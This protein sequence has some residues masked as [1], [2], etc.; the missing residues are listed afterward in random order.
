MSK[1]SSNASELSPKY[2]VMGFLYI[3]PMYGYELHKHLKTSLREVWHI[4]QSQAY[5]IIN[6]L[7]KDNWITAKTQPQEK[8]P[9][10][11]L[12]ALTQNGT[13]AFETWL[14]APTPGSARAIRVEFITRLFFAS[15]LGESQYFRLIQEQSDSIRISLEDLYSRLSI[16][17]SDLVFNRMGIDLRISQLK[18]ILDWVENSTK[19][20]KEGLNLL[21]N[22]DH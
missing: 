14:F 1:S 22:E 16:I 7:E 10:R 3:R 4:S 18:A 6:N 11:E 15:H 9:D 20:F 8:L 5:N 19:Y 21:T 17:P 13:I 2:A 12:L